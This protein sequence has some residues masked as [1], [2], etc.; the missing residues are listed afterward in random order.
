MT[1]DSRLSFIQ[2]FVFS[3]VL[4]MLTGLL[5]VGFFNSNPAHITSSATTASND[6]MPSSAEYPHPARMALE[7]GPL[8]IADQRPD[9]DYGQNLDDLQNQ[10]D[11][12]NNRIA[13]LEAQNETQRRELVKFYRQSLMIQPIWTA[14]SDP[15]G[16]LSLT[17]LQEAG[18]RLMEELPVDPVSFSPSQLNDLVVNFARFIQSERDQNLAFE[19]ASILPDDNPEKDLLLAKCLRRDKD[20]AEAFKSYLLA[21]VG[22]NSAGQWHH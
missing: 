1:R 9:Y 17:E 19:Q 21:S 8:R 3:Y 22:P 2:T 6:T 13:E 5:W 18:S 7:V 10:L 11:T 20:D 4:G 12:A 15:D 16:K 14:F